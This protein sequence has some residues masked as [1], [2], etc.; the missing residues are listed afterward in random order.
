[1]NLKIERYLK[2]DNR[3]VTTKD[4]T[5]EARPKLRAVSHYDKGS[6]KTKTEYYGHG[7]EV[8]VRNLYTD[9]V[10]NG[11]FVGVKIVH[12]WLANDETVGR[13]LEEDVIM[14]KGVAFDYLRKRR[15]RLI[16]YLQI[17]ANGTPIE[18]HVATILR[19]YKNEIELF[20]QGATKDFEDKVK[21]EKDETIVQLLSIVLDAEGKTVKDAILEQITIV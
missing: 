2:R 16:S 5:L 17:T 6:V 12:Q 7:D 19:F 20:I 15:Q 21:A 8:V 13:E 4:Y 11:V 1:M 3:D 9:I 14:N 10:E 18:S